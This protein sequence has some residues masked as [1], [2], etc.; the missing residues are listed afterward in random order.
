MTLKHLLLI[1]ALTTFSLSRVNISSSRL[2]DY[3]HLSGSVQSA[4]LEPSPQPTLSTNVSDHQLTFT[5]QNISAYS[6]LDYQITYTHD[7]GIQEFLQGSLENTDFQP[8]LSS[9]PIDLA[10]CSDSVCTPHL[11]LTNTSLEVT[12]HHLDSSTLTLTTNF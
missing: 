11:D 10:T 6:N 1:I 12:L 4:Q 5:L 8:N 7:S 9:P 2:S 3:T